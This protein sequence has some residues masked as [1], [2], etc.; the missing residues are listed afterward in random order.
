MIKIKTISGSIYTIEDN[1]LTRLSEKPVY[2]YRKMADD[3]SLIF[4]GV[5]ILNMEVPTVGQRCEFVTAIGPLLISE[6]TEI[7][8]V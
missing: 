1:T 2:S 7:E 5:E 4:N 8:N 6:I 3:P